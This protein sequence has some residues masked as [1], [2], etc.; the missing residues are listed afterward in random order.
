M[1]MF[2]TAFPQLSGLPQGKRQAGFTIIELMVTIAV[3][4]VLAT[5]AIPEM[6]YAIQNS[7]V[8]TAT[9]DT[10][11]SLLLARSEAI[12]RNSTVTMERNGASWLDG[13]NVEVGGTPITTQDP[14]AGVTAQCFST[15][16]ASSNCDAALSFER[17]GRPSSYIEFRYYND[18]NTA[19]AMRCV[20][21]DLSGRPGVTVDTNDDPS[22]GCN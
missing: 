3:V 13:W 10:H 11:T 2:T 14:L 18:E 21:V 16:N 9:S 17:T 20:R 1:N 22:D 15:P 5:L 19:I 4:G 12:K 7:R 8:R 6:N